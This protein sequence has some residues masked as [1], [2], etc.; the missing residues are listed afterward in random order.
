M[1]CHASIW[2]W[3]PF[4]GIWLSRSR[5]QRVDYPRRI[6]SQIDIY[7]TAAE[8]VPIRFQP[9]PQGRDEPD[10]CYLRLASVY[11]KLRH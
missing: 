1:R 10:A 4:F 3:S 7:A 5:H 9:I 2:R 8:S 11:R 6:F